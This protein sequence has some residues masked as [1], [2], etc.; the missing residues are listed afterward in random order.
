MN[1]FLKYSL[2]LIGTLLLIMI[3]LDVVYT[4]TIKD[5]IPRNKIRY[6]M[7]LKN[8]HYNVLFLGSSRVENSIVSSI[9]KEK[10]ISVLNMG[11]EGAVLGDNLLMLNI[12]RSNNVTF[13]KIFIQLD[14]LYNVKDISFSERSKSNLLP[15][16]R[17]KN[18]KEILQKTDKDFIPDYYFP[19]YRYMKNAYSI[20]FR[21]FINSLLDKN[22]KISFEDGYKPKFGTSHLEKSVLPKRIVDYS[23]VYEEI[24]HLCLSMGVKPVYFIAPFCSKLVDNDFITKLDSVVDNFYDYS[25]VIVNDNQF[26]NCGHLN[27][28]GAKEFTQIIIDEFYQK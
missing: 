15:L 19:F 23:I 1:R 26:Y 12:L 25:K 11:L 8:K 13:D 27:D 20:G 5:S 28:D 14:Y 4:K 21:E 3:F 2:K 7:S 22:P 17:E 9:F 24:N 10:G 18:V 16:I 6:A